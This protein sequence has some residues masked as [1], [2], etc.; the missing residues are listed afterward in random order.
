MKM[1]R[2]LA[3]MAIGLCVGCGLMPAEQASI[4]VSAETLPWTDMSR[5]RTYRWW[6]P[7]PEPSRRVSEREAL[8]DWYVRNGV[9]RELAARG[10][11]PDT[12]GAP[13]FV[14]RYTVAQYEG[15]TSS[16]QDY[17]QYRAEGGS[18][19]M[20]D[21]FMGYEVGTLE[22]TITDVATRRV[23]WRATASAII[24]GDAKGKRIDPAVREMMVR[25][26]A[27]ARAAQ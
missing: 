3:G 15:E 27:N 21:A 26:P 11:V 25:L 20:G 6:L 14:V 24:E 19:G 7:P 12:A 1:V 2:L 16:F 9:D 4:R 10:Y 17:L 22:I 23:A 8:I 5:Y 18:K 13:D